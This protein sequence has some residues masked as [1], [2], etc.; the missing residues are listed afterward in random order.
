MLSAQLFSQSWQWAQKYG[1]DGPDYNEPLHMALDSAGD[2]YV[3]GTYGNGTQ[4]N[5]TDLP[6][7]ASHDK[8]TYIA[9]FNKQGNC[10]WH[11]EINSQTIS[12]YASYLQIKNNKIYLFGTVHFDNYYNT[13][14]LD[15]TVYGG[16]LIYQWIYPPISQNFNMAFPWIPGCDFNV[17]IVFDLNGNIINKKF[18]CFNHFVNIN[19]AGTN[20]LN[21]DKSNNMYLFGNLFTYGTSKNVLYVDTIAASDSISLLYENQPVLFKLSPQF[22][23]LWYKRIVTAVNGNTY[24]PDIRIMDVVNDSTGNMY[25]TGYV[26]LID[27]PLLIS[28]PENVMFDNT[29][30]IHF[31]NSYDEVMFLM[32]LDTSGN[33]QWLKQTQNVLH[34]TTMDRAIALGNYISYCKEENKLYVSGFCVPKTKINPN[35]TLFTSTDTILYN[36]NRNYI[37]GMEFIACFDT[38]G[39]FLWYKLPPV[40]IS[41]DLGNLEYHNH[42]LYAGL[43][44]YDSLK[45]Q[46]TWYSVSGS[47]V[48]GMSYCKW[49]TQGNL[50]DVKNLTSTGTSYPNKTKLDAIGNMWVGGRLTNSLNFGSNTI[51]DYGVSYLARYNNQCSDTVQNKP[52]TG[53]PD[54][55]I[56]M[57]TNIQLIANPNNVYYQWQNGSHSNVYP[58]NYSAAGTDSLFAVVY[59]GKCYW[60]DTIVVHINDCTGVEETKENPLLVYPNPADD[61]I[62]ISMP[63]YCKDAQLTLL[64]ATGQIQ[65]STSFSSK[66]YTLDVSH[67]APGMY[68]VLLKTPEKVF[69]RKVCVK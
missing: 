58:I 14:F 38:G 20:T 11:K 65:F 42:A 5:N 34:D 1:A 7:F 27:A 33:I 30:G 36:Y 17:I 31:E 49:D 62:N 26:S 56:C 48:S 54:T 43:R 44:W 67:Y 3:F 53:I 13:Y 19:Q 50:L 55:I 32:K 45:F 21:I 15:T 59:N 64:N 37:G 10:I 29:H 66:A 25:Y 41:S 46:N 22:N 51:S 28:P 60:T 24:R 61:I 47:G 9:K 6:W 12:D 68:I 8:N 4:L 52:T 18:L 40:T 23:L 69:S 57:N 16:N 39:N 35:Y 2:A 63:Q